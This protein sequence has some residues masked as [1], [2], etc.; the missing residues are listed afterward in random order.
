MNYVVTYEAIVK[1]P[2]SRPPLWQDTE[3][4]C[5]QT[6]LDMRQEKGRE[7][8]AFQVKDRASLAHG[9]LEGHGL[10][11]GVMSTGAVRPEVLDSEP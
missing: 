3:R 10:D 5:L 4:W 7:E 11:P 8:R 9:R 6:R 1:K 2:E